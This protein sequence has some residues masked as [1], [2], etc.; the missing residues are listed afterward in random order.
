[1]R[2]FIPP[3]LPTLPLGRDAPCASCGYN[4]RGLME[5]GQCP[6][7]GAAIAGSMAGSRPLYAE[8]KWVRQTRGGLAVLLTAIGIAVLVSYLDWWMNVGG[9]NTDVAPWLTLVQWL[10]Q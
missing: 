1:A 10:G 4:L 5:L 9:R 2:R 7:C 3:T 6:E 8:E